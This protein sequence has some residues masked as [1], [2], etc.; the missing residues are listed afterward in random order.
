MTKVSK[1]H[2]SGIDTIKEDTTWESDKNTKKHHTQESQDVSSFPAGNHKAAMNRQESMTKPN[3]NNKNDPQK[4]HRLG[5]VSKSFKGGLKLVL[6]YQ[7][8]PYFRCGS[9]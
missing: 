9:K 4:K 6:W 5:M 1:K 8:H 7:P 2:R 3:I